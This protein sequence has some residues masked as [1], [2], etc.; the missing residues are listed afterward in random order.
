MHTSGVYPD[1]KRK[2][3]AANDDKIKR[4]RPETRRSRIYISPPHSNLQ[5]LFHRI[6]VSAS[7]LVRYYSYYYLS[8]LKFLPP[9]SFLPN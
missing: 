1:D 2:A 8:S 4:K 9:A 7:P 5:S 3:N 6:F